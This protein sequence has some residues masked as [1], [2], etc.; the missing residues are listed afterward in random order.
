MSHVTLHDS[1]LEGNAPVA[2]M[3]ITVSGTDSFR[4]T[5]VRIRN[6][7]LMQ[8]DRVN[9]DILC[10]GYERHDDVV[11]QQ[12]LVDGFGGGGLELCREGLNRHTVHFTGELQSVVNIITVYSC[13]A[14][15]THPSYAGSSWDGRQLFR[16]MA[17]ITNATILAADATQWY[18]NR[19]V[20]ANSQC[21][22]VI[23]FGSFEGNLLRF[24]P[25]GSVTTV[26][27]NALGP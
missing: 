7:A 18:H 19:G 15:E 11:G 5:M 21:T 17:A 14:A 10:H 2:D 12:T 26:E 8:I 27:S 16:E 9:L 22:S 4:G 13:S 20:Y 1:R 24:T 6:Y 3:N 23:D 25:D